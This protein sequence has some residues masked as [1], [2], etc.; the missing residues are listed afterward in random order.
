MLRLKESPQMTLFD[1]LLPPE[2]VKLS[3]ELAKVDVL[4][5]DERFLAPFIKHFTSTTGRATIPMETYLRIMMYLKFRYQLGYEVLVQE[6]AD[7]IKWRIFCRI[8]FDRPAPHSTTLIKLTKRFG[9]EVIENLNQVLVDKARERKLVRGRKLRLDTTVVDANIH[10]PTDASLLSDCARAITR[11]VKRI[12]KQGQGIRAEF[13]DRTR[14]IKKRIYSISK[15]LRR[16]TG[17][18]FKEVRKITGTI[19]KIVEAVVGQALAETSQQAGS[20]VTST[21]ASLEKA[22]DIAKKIIAQTGSVQQETHTSRTD[23]EHLR[24]GGSPDHEG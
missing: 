5:D 3:D 12:K 23:S 4:L 21:V 19:M 22:I 1:L 11:T 8:P 2:L 18:A 16:R 15:V 24:C 7:S 14:S 10:Y 17:N 13:H 20:S 6:I 9:P